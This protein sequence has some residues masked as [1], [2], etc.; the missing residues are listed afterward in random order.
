MNFNKLTLRVQEALARAQGLAHEKHQ[1]Q[2][3]VPHLFL[4]ML[5]QEDG[6]TSPLLDRLGIPVESLRQM[7][8]R[9]IG[10]LPQ[11]V[12]ASSM[13]Q[14][15]VTNALNQVLHEAQ[16]QAEALGDE[17]ISTEHL[18]LSMA[19]VRSPVRELLIQAGANRENIL[20]VL[21]DVRGSQRVTDEDPESKYQALEKYTQNLTKLT[22]SGKLDPVIGRDEEI[23]RV[24][25]ILSRRT[26]NNPVLIGEPGVGKTAIVEG[27]AQRII[28][29]DV[30]ESLK[31]KEVIGLDLGSLIAGSRFRGEFE[32]R[33]KAVL[34]EVQTAAGKFILFIDEL[35][36]IIGAGATEGSLDASNMLKPP[37][38]RGELHA[39]GAT[40]L[41][42]YQKYIERD[43]AFER[44]FQPVI[45]G[46]P[47][48]EDTVAI[49]RG[50]KEKYEL[51][52]G[53]RIT[54][55]ALVSAV[56]LSRRYIHDR[57]LPDKAIDLI[58]EATSG[59]R[60]EIDSMPTELDR[61]RRRQRQLEIER[62]AL[63]KETDKA[64]KKRLEAVQ[65]EIADLSEQASQLELRW[66]KEKDAISRIRELQE[67]IDR[68]KIEA[69]RAERGGDFERVAVLRYAE[70][71]KRE[72][73]MKKEK[74]KLD[75]IAKDDRILKEEVTE[76]DI[77]AVVARWTGVPVEK[78]LQADLARLAKMEE[79][80]KK[81][82]VGQEDALRAV[83]SA[84][85]RSRA[86][87]SDPNRP[88]GSFIFMGPTGV[89]KTELTKALAEFLFHDENALIRLDMSE[90][91]ERHATSRMIGSPPGYVG[92]DEGGQLTEMIRRR[93][94]SVVLFDEIEKAHPDVFNVL[95]QILDDGRLTDAKG[96]TVDFK[97]TVIVMTSNL[98]SDIIQSYARE[99][100][101]RIG[102]RTSAVAAD[103]ELKEK[104][105]HELEM[106]FK[107]EFLNRIDEIII[108]HA[109]STAELEKIVGLQLKKVEERLKER[110]INLKV[111]PEAKKL[112]AEKGYDPVYGARPLK[113]AI[114]TEIL[115][116]LSL[117]LLQGNIQDGQTIRVTAQGGAIT[118]HESK[119]PA[120]VEG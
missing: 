35:H 113:R 42:E 16:H 115:D 41:K 93:P 102:Y 30:P 52:H 114:Q 67:E 4:A 43:P 31:D 57:F 61:A 84:I 23:R 83:S 78:M 12:I 56:Q 9:V 72:E 77:A 89:G 111:T 103:D 63:K 2:V 59:L 32:E 53:V 94:Y 119:V 21:Q 60:L 118:L 39:I 50:I 75:K 92:F 101:G 54:D 58:D 107:P 79:D 48:P 36:T 112:L 106:A 22:R 116:P 44:R 13:G 87:I 47:T 28:S 82:M 98:G 86:G 73:A 81:R 6:L 1:Q 108:F 110:G 120:L 51:H 7:T 3:D 117:E 95:L 68:L 14:M 62:E 109:L 74:G 18:L 10:A 55:P 88:I 40:T 64:S 45:V 97:N 29:G 11:I 65:K 100:S 99:Q 15:Y 17:Y 70:L 20:A 27:L 80:L 26:K 104:I 5:D 76:E 25:Q 91:M 49:L 24:I 90:Y 34:K 38:A 105:T 69:E 19:E 96:R 66:Q 71:P 8:T 46:E 33:L 85:R 37:L